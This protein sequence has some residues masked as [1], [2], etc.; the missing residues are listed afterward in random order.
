MNKNT[1]W[2]EVKEVSKS[3]K[4]YKM[5]LILLKYFPAI[6]MRFL[7]FPIGFFYYLFSKN[8]RYISKNFLTT[9][10]QYNSVNPNYKLSISPLKHIISFSLNLVENV[11][12]WAGKFSFNHVIWQKDDVKDLVQNIE[13]KK[14]SVLITSHLGNAQMLR[15]LASINEAGTNNKIKITTISDTDLTSGFSSLLKEI[16]PDSYLQI[17]NS[18]NIGPDTIFLLQKELD[19][20]GVVVIA[21]DRIS[22]NTDRYIPLNFFGK[23]ANFPYG[24][25][26]L[27][28]LLNVPTYFVF[29]LRQKDFKLNSKYEMYVCKNKI[30]FDCKR[31]EREERIIK[32][33]ENFKSELEKHTTN[34]PYQWY[35]FF[36]FWIN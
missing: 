8:A 5:I 18:N 35:N 15:A 11:Q 23:T 30:D 2:Y 28:A 17:I 22:A 7:V 34:H 14:G 12:S 19:E 16:N 10:S 3:G 29:G 20:G 33:A 36:D 27:I 13:T 26:L 25:F 4:G 21:G 6:I 31:K 1:N 32:T 24:V 9:V